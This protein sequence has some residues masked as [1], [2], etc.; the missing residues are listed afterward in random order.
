M[1]L[2][3]LLFIWYLHYLHIDYLRYCN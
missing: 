3:K 2:W 1:S